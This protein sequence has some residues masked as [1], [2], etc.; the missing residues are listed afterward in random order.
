VSVDVKCLLKK[1]KVTHLVFLLEYYY[2]PYNYS[3]NIIC[4]IYYNHRMRYTPMTSCNFHYGVDIDSL[5]WILGQDRT[6]NN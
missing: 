1:G 6:T 3:L 4:F 2:S 5:L